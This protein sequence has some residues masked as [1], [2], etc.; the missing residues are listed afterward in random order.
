V[1]NLSLPFRRTSLFC[2]EGIMLTAFY[3]LAL[4][5]AKYDFVGFLQNADRYR[6][7]MLLEGIRFVFVLGPNQGFREDAL[8]PAPPKRALMLNNILIP[9]CFMLGIPVEIII[10]T[11]EEARELQTGEIFPMGYLVDN[12]VNHYGAHIMTREFRRGNYPLKPVKKIEKQPDLITITL[13]ECHYWPTRN[14]NRETWLAA[15]EIIKKAGLRVLF[16]PDVDSLPIEDSD[17]EA[18]IDLNR[19]AAIYESAEHNFFV[20][21]GPAWM[22]AAMPNTNCTIFKI[23]AEGAVCVS[24][25]YYRNIGFPKGSQIGRPNHKIVWED[26]TKEHVLPV[27][28]EVIGGII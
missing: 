5:P 15:A 12:P 21:N 2:V 10:A 17:T 14:G 11:R 6:K 18:S 25:K 1:Q 4:S 8:P 28:H 26:D 24:E 23:L 19:R 20:N 22:A 27:V 13:R 16:I 7:L 9:M 3:D